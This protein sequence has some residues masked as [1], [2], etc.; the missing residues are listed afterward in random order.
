MFENRIVLDK[1]ANNVVKKI[2]KEYEARFIH[3]SENATYVVYSDDK[4]LYTIRISRS[5]YRTMSQLE[6]E[7][8]WLNIIKNTDIPAI[9][10]VDIMGRYVNY[11]DGYFVTLFEYIDGEMPE[12]NDINVM[13]ECGR[14]AALLHNSVK[15]DYIDRPVWSIDNMTGENGLWGNWRLNSELTE[16]DIILIDNIIEESKLKI[17][18]YKTN[19]YG[20]IHID[21]RM[22]NLIKSDKFYAIDFDDCGFGY[23]IQD[24]AAALSFMETSDNID[25]LKSVWY[26]GYE[27]IS[28]LTDEDKAMVDTFIFLRR[29]QLLAWI[30]SHCESDYVK[31]VSKGF[32]KETMKFVKNYNTKTGIA[33]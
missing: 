3:L 10:P 6:S 30:T 22:T 20:L 9:I 26:K 11:I 33:Y 29:I 13:Y 14:L 15:P 23:Y 18:D 12:Y 1:I 24:L 17:N 7:I 27:E 4:P 31:T 19:K 16:A 21:L 28:F 8:A 5:D 25:E 2:N 32:V